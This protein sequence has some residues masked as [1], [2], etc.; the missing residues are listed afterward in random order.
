MIFNSPVITP[1]L[2]LKPESIN[3]FYRF[4]DMSKDPEVMR[5]IGD[6]SIYHWSKETALKKY[7]AGINNQG[8]IKLGNLAVYARDSGLYIGWCGVTFSKFLDHAELGYR[9]CRDAWGQGYA[10]EAAAAVIAE[11]FQKTEMDRVLAIVHPANSASIRVLE[12]LGFGCIGTRFSRAVDAA[13]PVY[14]LDRDAFTAAKD[15]APEDR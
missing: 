6:G 12:K 7:Q 15:S 1:R 11:T 8:T 5:W 3:D 2:T 10:T 9:Y 14:A 13:L 4:F